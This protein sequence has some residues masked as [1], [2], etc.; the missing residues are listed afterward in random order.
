MSKRSHNESTDG[1]QDPVGPVSKR[2]RPEPEDDK[3]AVIQM[4]RNKVDKLQDEVERLTKEPSPAVENLKPQVQDS[5][6]KVDDSALTQIQLHAILTKWSTADLS[7]SY[8]PL[9]DVL[10]PAL[11]T[12]ALT[13]SGMKKQASD[14]SYERLEWVGDSYLY[15]IASTLVFQTFPNSD[16]GI[17]A[18]HRETLIKN[19]TIAKYTRHYGLDKIANMPEE[20]KVQGRIGGTSAGA[21]SK[22]KVLADI[23]EAYVG[24]V[25][26]SD[27]EHGLQRATDWLKALWAPELRNEIRGVENNKGTTSSIGPKTELEQAIFWPKETKIEY[28]DLPNHKNDKKT[29]LPLFTVG[30]YLTGWGETEKQLGFGVAKGKKEAGQK[31][32]QMALENKKVLQVYIDKKNK[33]KEERVTAES[34]AH[35][36]AAAMAQEILADAP[37]VQPGRVQ[38]R[39]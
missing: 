31:A 22:L 32:A 7:E 37:W 30:C 10:S 23:F 38:P 5:A 11:K 18:H 6:D 26:L 8:P 3:D 16:P 39:K 20:F 19:V 15:A 14:A 1:V 33:K 27:P 36:A 2:T 12:A 9:P 29:G 34:R 17:L 24:A 25:V 4:L 21:G 35:A 28:K 13:H